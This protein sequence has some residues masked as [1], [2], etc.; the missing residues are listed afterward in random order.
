METINY[1]GLEVPLDN[2]EVYSY[3]SSGKNL[4]G[5]FQMETHSAAKTLTEIQPVN[6]EDLSLVNS[7]N[8]PGC[9][10]FT[11][12]IG[13]IRRG[14]KEVKYLH[15]I[16]EPFLKDTYGFLIY[17]ESVLQI[18][19]KLAGFSPIQSSVLL[20]ALGKKMDDKMMSLKSAFIDGMSSKSNISKE[21]ADK[22]FNVFID[23]ANYSFNKSHSVAYSLQ[24][25]CSAYIKLNYP[26][27][28]FTAALNFSQ[29][30][31]EPL[32]EVFDYVS[33]LPDFGI[34]LLPPSI[35]NITNKFVMEE[36][37]IRYPIGLIK[38]LGD[39]MYPQLEMI[40]ESQIKS[41][42]SCIEAL[43]NSKLNSR[44]IESIIMSGSMDVY[45]IARED[46]LL[47]FWF[48]SDLQPEILERFW[49]FKNGSSLSIE[50]INNFLNYKTEEPIG[51]KGKIK[52]RS[53]FKTDATRQ[54][55]IVKFN[56]YNELIA[57]FKQNLK[58]CYY[59][60]ETNTL[61]YSLNYNF[62]NKKK[63]YQEL[64]D[65]DIKNRAESFGLVEEIKFYRSDKG[66]EYGVYNLKFDKRE[67]FM[68]FGENFLLAKN[69]IREGD[70]IT[71]PCEIE[72]K[73][74]RL[75]GVRKVNEEIRKCEFYKRDITKTDYE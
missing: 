51:K 59:I 35:L 25:Y 45:N 34:K 48:L 71:F 53:H 61:G 63:T 40:T 43:M 56:E 46:A 66:N 65:M 73:G 62:S 42:D 22:I 18:A 4:K 13:A 8:R 7:L 60:W 5:I 37:N 14:T 70:Y 16:F 55:T 6:I 69:L 39:K 32:Q 21:I 41:F 27:E 31:G 38:G 67:R 1:M 30:E 29:F 26:L 2:K 24:G 49:V 28:F 44:S 17:Q 3:L 36:G 33:E 52:I 12:D 64:A 75:L 47:F 11:Q 19:Q 20:K 15:P 57:H 72:E 54:K 10:K 23:F 74:Y 9:F 68:F 50:L 58:L